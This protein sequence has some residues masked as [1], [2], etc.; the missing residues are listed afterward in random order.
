MHHIVI[1]LFLKYGCF[2]L[3]SFISIFPSADEN[4]FSENLRRIP[5]QSGKKE[6]N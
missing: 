2:I 6:K 4:L 1:Q 5:L 3:A